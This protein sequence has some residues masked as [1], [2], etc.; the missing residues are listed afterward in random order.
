MT[1]LTTCIDGLYRLA[2]GIRN[3]G[4]P[5][6]LAWQRHLVQADPLEVRD[7]ATGLSFLCR[8]PAFQMFGEVFHLHLYDLPWVP[9]RQGDVVIDIGANH[10]FY[11]LYAASQG[12]RVYA[13]EP[14]RDTFELLCQNIRRNGLQERITPI[15]CAV[16][17]EAGHTMLSVVAQLAGGMSSIE[18][19]FVHASGARVLE[20]YPV[21]SIDLPGFLVNEAIDA[22]RCLKLDCEGSELA[23]L[24]SL[25]DRDWQRMDGIAAE[26]HPEAYRPLDLF[27]TIACTGL[28]QIGT[29]DTLRHYGVGSDVLLCVREAVLRERLATA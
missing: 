18:P 6:Q 2:R 8:A 11:S 21:A 23:I 9:I 14:Q 19:A 24:R 17:A 27:D 20:T 13:F 7:R 26:V 10:G 3:Y 29:L 28:F 1:D 15:P 22:V 25:A 16:A 5:L 12:A 4:N